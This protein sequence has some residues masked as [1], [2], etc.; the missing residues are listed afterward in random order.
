[1]AY[2]AHHQCQL[3]RAFD[4]TKSDAVLNISLFV[5]A[6]LVSTVAAYALLVYLEIPTQPDYYHILAKNLF[7]GKGFVISEDG[8]PILFRGHIY[9][10]FIAG[11]YTLFGVNH[12]A[13]VIAQVI[14]YSFNV[15]L[16][17]HLISEFFSKKVGFYTAIIYSL[18]PFS[19]FYV[20]RALPTTL[21]SFLF[22]LFLYS[23]YYFYKRPTYI[24]AILCGF[25]QGLLVLTKVFFKGFPLFLVGYLF[26]S[27]IVHRIIEKNEQTSDSNVTI[28]D[29]L[30]SYFFAFRPPPALIGVIFLSF[31]M[32]VS[33]MLIRNY[34]LL[35]EFP[36][37]GGGGGYSFWIGNHI[38]TDGRDYDEL[39]PD[40]FYKLRKLEIDI[41]GNGYGLSYE[42]DT[43]LYSAGIKELYQ[44]P[45]QS[46]W[47]MFKKA[48][49]L[50]VDI[51]SPAMKKYQIYVTTVQLIII[52]PAIF[53][54]LLAINNQIL[55]APFISVLFYYQSLHAVVMATIRYAI[56]VM[57][58]I[59]AFAVY[60]I[61][62][63]NQ[64]ITSAQ[65][66]FHRHSGND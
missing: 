24:T 2:K 9:P 47:L 60:W 58:I 49:R 62:D 48:G 1:M 16:V 40:E 53:G 45:G 64:S 14:L 41:I 65:P 15:L 33:P 17:Y 21:F 54:L 11:L 46:L 13:V 50:W 29:K 12:L 59:I 52:I 3:L 23:L 31:A 51:Y 32:T 5:F 7:L 43:K 37:L 8:D 56:P 19:I 38:E 39:S 66:K 30:S 44:H 4:M 6:L 55:I 26:L 34:Q 18:Y 35:G 61:L 20:V 63:R 57:P 42:N 36:V 25:M 10:L 28:V 27:L 22:L